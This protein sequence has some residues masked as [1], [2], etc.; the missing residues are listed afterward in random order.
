MYTA[1]QRKVLGDI[2]WTD[3][4]PTA[5]ITVEGMYINPAFWGTLNDIEKDLLIDHEL[6]HLLLEHPKRFPEGTEE[7]NIG[8]DAA[9]ND[10]LQKKYCGTQ[11]PMSIIPT[12]Y[13]G[14]VFPSKYNLPSNMTTEWYIEAMKQYTTKQ[15]W[16]GVISAKIKLN[17]DAQEATDTIKGGIMAGIDE[18]SEQIRILSKYNPKPT[19]VS[20]VRKLSGKKTA[21]D[22]FDFIEK[23]GYNRKYPTS[24]LPS[25]HLIEGQGKIRRNNVILFLDYS[26]SCQS[27]LP[28]FE[29]AAAQIPKNFFN[30]RTFLFADN[31]A[32][33]KKG[34]MNIGSG[35]NYHTLPKVATENKCDMVWCFTDGCG[36]SMSI[37]S[38]T[39]SKW[40]WFLSENYLNYIPKGC[41]IH[42]LKHFV[43]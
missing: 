20:L 22:T 43:V 21:Y 39:R 18:Y 23:F 36:T 29:K 15:E 16:G 2:I 13:K 24:L 41:N 10:L 38:A 27:M 11:N 31:V 35:T 42:F 19:F 6:H 1:I 32:E 37:P 12:L 8:E 3:K 4:V 7:Q 9:I 34:K 14:G 25:E 30:I 5:G 40:H 17:K 33:Y 26:G 28:L